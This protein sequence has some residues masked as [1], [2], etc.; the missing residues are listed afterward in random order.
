MRLATVLT[1]AVLAVLPAA[2]RAQERTATRPGLMCASAEAL[3]KLTLPDGSSRTASARPR[4]EDLRIKAEGG[5]LDLRPG[6]SRVMVVEAYHLT[7]KVTSD[8]GDGGGAR[9]FIVPNI[10]F[11]PV[12]NQAAVA[13]PPSPPTV[14]GTSARL[15]VTITADGPNWCA[16]APTLRVGVQN[17]AMLDSA[18]LRTLLQQFAQAMIVRRCPAAETVHYSGAVGSGLS[19]W[20]ATASAADGWAVSSADASASAGAGVDL[21][22]LRQA[23]KPAPA[24]PVPRSASTV[25]KTPAPLNLAPPP[26]PL[27]P[28]PTTVSAV[29]PTAPAPFTVGAC[30]IAYPGSPQEALPLVCTCDAASVDSGAVFGTD[31][32]SFDSPPCRAARHAGVL[33]PDGGTAAFI[34]VP[35]ARNLVGSDRNGVDS[36]SVNNAAASIVVRPV[37]PKLVTYIRDVTV[38]QS[39]PALKLAVPT[40]DG[41]LLIADPV[42]PPAF[43]DATTAAPALG[44]AIDLPDADAVS[45]PVPPA[46]LSGGLPVIPWLAQQQQPIASVSMQPIPSSPA[47][48]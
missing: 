45:L 28:D 15:G 26:P 16:R 17:G 35:G 40:P 43:P 27:V 6:S 11:E 30:P 41:R 47:H 34:P 22:D 32:Y 10:D 42:L 2:A 46:P 37:L 20:Q 14:L 3:A 44:V 19:Q 4:P 13:A 23:P 5:C 8:P 31:N 18:E 21:D 9:L 24:L 1:L 33:G 36:G 39:D 38:R 25:P 48:E 12:P 29:T 7:S